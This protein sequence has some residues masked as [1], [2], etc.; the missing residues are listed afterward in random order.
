MDILRVVAGLVIAVFVLVPIAF[1]LIGA[2]MHIT[3]RW[4]TGR[5]GTRRQ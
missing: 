1:A 2:A 3:R 5:Q 4:K